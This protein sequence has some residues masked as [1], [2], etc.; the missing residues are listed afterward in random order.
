M[1]LELSPLAL[2]LILVL[3]FQLRRCLLA[4]G[5][6]AFQPKPIKPGKVSA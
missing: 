2:F 1:K 5:P 6:V 4:R 3:L